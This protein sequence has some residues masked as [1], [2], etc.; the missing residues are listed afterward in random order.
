MRSNFIE[1]CVAVAAICF[2]TVTN[3]MADGGAFTRGCAARDMQIT[4]MLERSAISPEELDRAMHK[5]IEAR[6]MCFEGYV[7][8]ALALYDGVFQRLTTGWLMSGQSRDSVHP[9]SSVREKD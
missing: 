8:D 1:Y 2:G 3:V 6:M 7:V 5:M 4:M 9:Q